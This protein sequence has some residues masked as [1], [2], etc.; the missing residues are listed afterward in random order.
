MTYIW[1]MN[2]AVGWA[3]TTTILRY[4]FLSVLIMLILS[5]ITPGENPIEVSLIFA[6]FFG[7]IV[8]IY[9]E[10]VGFGFSSRW[11]FMFR[12][13]AGL[14]IIQILLMLTLILNRLV[15]KSLSMNVSDEPILVSLTRAS[16]IN[17][18]Y[19]GWI[20]GVLVLFLIELEKSLGPR[21]IFDLAWGRY[22]RPRREIRVIMFLDLADSTALAE[23]L[24]DSMYYA[25]INDCFRIIRPPVVKNKG[26]VLK[27]I[28]DEVIIS[29]NDS[30]AKNTGRFLDLF[31]DF[32]QSL[33]SKHDYFMDTYGT[34][35]KFRAGAHRGPVVV[36]Y[37]GDI[38][39]QKDLN[40]DAMNTTARIT[41][42]TKKL[43]SDLV[44]SRQLHELIGD[45]AD[46]F[47]GPLSETVKGKVKSLELYRLK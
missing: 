26:E 14:F 45:K 15:L 13:L 25:F 7:V 16:N 43:D 42:L 17:F 12:M 24:G 30:K 39:K 9:H 20:F 10:L 1:D 29:W 47:D 44:I 4:G 40:G 38:K 27:Y 34:F 5:I 22:R 11:P 6:F 28:G 18:Y 8:G 23:Q 32:K 19:K 2:K 41:G 21:Y 36:A 31:M 46:F 37:I 35:P 3:R 33:E